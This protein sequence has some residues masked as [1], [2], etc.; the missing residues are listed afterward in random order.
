MNIQM[1]GIAEIQTARL[2]AESERQAAKDLAPVQWD[3]S[4]LLD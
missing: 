1:E 4:E 2:K 3:S